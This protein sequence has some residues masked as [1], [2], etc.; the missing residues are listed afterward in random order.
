M[1]ERKQ[2][3]LAIPAVAIV[4]A[5]AA[6]WIPSPPRP[7]VTLAEASSLARV[8]RLDE[9]EA[10]LGDLLRRHP[11]HPGA[12]VLAAQ[13]ALGRDTHEESPD[14]DRAKIALDYLDRVRTDDRSIA[15]TV[16]LLRGNA[17]H[18]LGR[19]DE[20]ESS[21]IEAIRL[22]PTVPEAGWAL[23]NLYYLERR[24]DDARRLALRL[25]ETEPDRRDRV[26]LLLELLRQDVRPRRTE[27]LVVHFDPI[28]RRLP[29]GYRPGWHSAGRSSTTP[30]PIGACRSSDRPSRTIRRG[31]SRGRPCC[32]GW[33]TPGRSRSLPGSSADCPRHSRARRDGR[34]SG[35]GSPRSGATGRL[36]RSPTA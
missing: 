11:D 23:L 36:R 7:E 5:L 2:L 31:P 18:R 3:V 13:V 15:A 12:N 9:A 35:P 33:M 25:H 10:K 1:I 22:D 24:R 4:A 16:R 32:R 30:R 29:D 28:V 19:L 21:W 27:S 14:L 8:G 17:E 26:Q 34:D 6:Y 20:A